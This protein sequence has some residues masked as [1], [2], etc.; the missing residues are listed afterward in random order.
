MLDTTTSR[1]YR[2]ETAQNQQIDLQV[3]I[4]GQLVGTTPGTLVGCGSLNVIAY[5]TDLRVN[6]FSCSTT[7]QK[8]QR[9]V[10]R[11]EFAVRY[12]LVPKA[13]VGALDGYFDR[14]WVV[15]ENDS[16]IVFDLAHEPDSP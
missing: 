5:M 11:P 12:V 13:D 9:Q 4:G 14:A 3:D 10:N 15:A 1:Y 2:N 8:I 7:V 6:E 16:L